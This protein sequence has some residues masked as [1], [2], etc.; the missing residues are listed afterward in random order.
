M[1]QSSRKVQNK[2]N[3]V[4]QEYKTNRNK[5]E[6]FKRRKR[7]EYKITQQTKP[8]YETKGQQNRH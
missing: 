7:E 8:K 6:Q 3:R 5:E 1:S 2:H 4:L